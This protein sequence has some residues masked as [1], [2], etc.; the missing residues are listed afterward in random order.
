[1]ELINMIEIEIDMDKIPN[2]IGKMN[3]E[4]KKFTAV[5]VPK[6]HDWINSQLPET[7]EIIKVILT[8]RMQMWIG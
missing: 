7:N 1:M 5:D 8:G 2:N 6:I 4:F 3:G